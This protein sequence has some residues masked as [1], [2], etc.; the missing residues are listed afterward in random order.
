[1][2]P[3]RKSR[4]WGQLSFK[5][6]ESTFIYFDLWEKVV[7]QTTFISG[8]LPQWVLPTL[9]SSHFLLSFLCMWEEKNFSSTTLWNTYSLLPSSLLIFSSM[10]PSS[11]PQYYSQRLSCLHCSC[12]SKWCVGNHI[13]ND[14]PYG[15]EDILCTRTCGKI[16]I[17]IDA[18]TRT[19]CLHPR[20]SISSSSVRMSSWKVC[21][22]PRTY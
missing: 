2:L 9:S 1:M 4:S 6:F 7:M 3:S 14:F 19:F 11:Y 20:D 8:D 22:Y 10:W 21:G 16:R 15:S 5:G 13:V 12:F 18:C 17:C